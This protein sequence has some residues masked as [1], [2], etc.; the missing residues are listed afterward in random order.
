MLLEHLLQPENQHLEEAL[1]KWGS[2]AALG[3][4]VLGGL[5]A[6]GGTGSQLGGREHLDLAPPVP[7][8][9]TQLPAAPSAAVAAPTVTVAASPVAR[10]TP[11]TSGV[12]ANFP[13][14]L[15]HIRHMQ[16]DARVAAFVT[17][18]LP[19][20]Q[21]ENTRIQADRARARRIISN[22]NPSP[23]D[24]AWLQE[25]RDHYGADNNQ[26][27]MR[28]MD[29]VPASLVLAQAAIESGWGTDHIARS[30][31]AFFGQRATS[32]SH[33]HVLGPVG[34]RYRAYDSPAHSIRS[35]M[36]NLNTHAA[37]QSLRAERTALRRAN[38]PLSGI[39]LAGGLERYSTRG[40]DYVKQVRDLIRSR[41]LHRYD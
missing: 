32:R 13:S 22:A 21:A 20:I 36:H 28:R 34:E 9:S 33:G 37:Y 24:A 4:G 18:M 2:L 16:P 6:W 10:T 3:A 7:R 26:E 19:L 1:G 15:H 35:Y 12:H 17:T 11:A 40:A 25:R 41:N 8:S 39:Q 5:S 27:L 30:A 38:K 23:Q 31:N 14:S 29:Q